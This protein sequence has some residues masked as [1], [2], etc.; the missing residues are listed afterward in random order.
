MDFRW[1]IKYFDWLSFLWKAL[2]S[3][4][5]WIQVGSRALPNDRDELYIGRSDQINVGCRR[6]RSAVH[7]PNA[8]LIK[9]S[10]STE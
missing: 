4:F 2:A 6:V 7:G 9:T 3:Q 8:L 10:D 1:S 5:L